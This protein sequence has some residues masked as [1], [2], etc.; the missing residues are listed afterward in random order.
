MRDFKGP[1]SRRRSCC[2]D[3]R[4]SSVLARAPAALDGPAP[5]PGVQASLPVTKSRSAMADSQALRGNWPDCGPKTQ[6]W[7]AGHVP[8]AVREI[9]CHSN[10]IHYSQREAKWAAGLSVWAGDMPASVQHETLA[11]YTV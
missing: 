8:Q 3:P 5:S 6:M 1:T 9:F 11:G 4:P 2:F 7:H 10:P